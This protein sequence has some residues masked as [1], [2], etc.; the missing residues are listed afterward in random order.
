MTVSTTSIVRPRRTERR[1]GI[2]VFRSPAA[3][4]SLVWLI[5]L[6]LASLTGPLWLRYGPL[7]Q[8]LTAVLQGPSL[9]HLLGTDELGRDLL[10]RLVTAA[11]PTIFTAIIV[12]IVAIG[13]TVPITLWAARSLRGEGVVNRIS[14]IVLSLPGTVIILA[15]IAAVGTNM[16]LVMIAFGLLLFGAMYKVLFGQAKSLHKQLFVEAAAVDGVRPMTASIRHVLPNMST[17]VIVQFVLLFGVGIGFQAGLAFIGLGPQPPEPTWGGMIQTA[18]R[19]I[20]QQPWM[21]VPTGAILALTIIAANSLAD[22]LAGGTAVP[23]P[24]VALRRK[25][26]KTPVTQIS[27]S[28]LSDDLPAEER[29]DGEAPEAFGMMGDASIPSS[30]VDPM[31]SAHA[32]PD[33]VSIADI[34][35]AAT[36]LVVESATGSGDP[37]RDGAPPVKGELVVRDLV[38]GVEGGPALVTGVSL[39]VRPGSVMGLVGESGCG[40]SVTSYAL[41][42]LLSPGLSV[43]SGRIDWNGADLAHASEKTMQRVRGHEIA[44]ISQEPSRALDPMFTVRSQLSTA[45]KRLRGVS[46]PEAKRIAGELLGDVGINDVPR[47][48][49]SYPHQLSGGMAQRVAIALALAGR[50]SLLIADEPTTALDVTIQA[51]ILDLLRGLIAERG[52]SIILVTH[53]L[54]VVADICDDVSVMYAGEI[55]ETGSVRDVLVRPEHPYTMALLAADPHAIP[56]LDSTTRLASIPG[57]VPLPGSWTSGCRF[58]PRCRFAKDECLVTVPLEARVVGR[59]AVRCVRHDEVRGRQEEWRMPVATGG[60]R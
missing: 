60:E 31:R 32:M 52:M 34:G 33:V 39:R 15:F 36:P 55:V 17:T 43:R 24:L 30:N 29:T 18:S 50:P 54:G 14:E 10:S 9:A 45:V 49:K 42:G 44:F 38:I 35:D 41:L 57:Q 13:V 58:A 46:G 6:V 1:L 25:K 23:P 21:M 48:L 12:P 53:D 16:P 8:D 27:A 11:A 40:K 3:V 2:R 4:I 19:F 47:V 20:F 5:G 26:S 37:G 51:E 56:D 22:V 59:G 28:A 7:E